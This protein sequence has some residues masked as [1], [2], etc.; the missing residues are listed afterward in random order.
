MRWRW[1]LLLIFTLWA[2]EPA[3]SATVLVLQ[4]HNNSQYTDLNWVGE[5]IA[6]TLRTEFSAANEIVLDRDSRAEGM[7]RLALRPDASFTKA[8]LI[9]LGQ[10]LDV[11]YLCYG[12][13]DVNSPAGDKELKNSSIRVT[14]RFLDL[15]KMHE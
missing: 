15:R 11:D 2:A 14:A 5:S 6:E 1:P 12:N 3:Q 9:R 13:Y 8:T 7:R 10:T 4:F